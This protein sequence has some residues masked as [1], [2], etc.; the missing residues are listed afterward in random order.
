MNFINT[1]SNGQLLQL[2][3]VVYTVYQIA[4][5]WLCNIECVTQYPQY[6]QSAIAV[7]VD[8]NKI[9]TQHTVQ[10]NFLYSKNVGAKNIEYSKPL[11]SGNLQPILILGGLSTVGY[12][13]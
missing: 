10:L 12:L 1:Y 9:W 3:M 5:M 13:R 8:P 4:L 2:V 11:Q 6:H 7:T